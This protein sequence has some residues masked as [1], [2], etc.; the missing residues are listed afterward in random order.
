ME[1]YCEGMDKRNPALQLPE[2][3]DVFL[4]IKNGHLDNDLKLFNCYRGIPICHPAHISGIAITCRA[5]RFKAHINQLL[6]MEL[7]KKTVIQS[8]HFPCGLLAELT[9]IHRKELEV[10]LRGFVYT[11]V[12]INKRDNIRIELQPPLVTRLKYGNKDTVARIIDMCIPS[13]AA[14]LGNRDLLVE[15][16]DDIRLVMNLATQQ[17]ER[18]LEVP[19]DIFRITVDGENSRFIFNLQHNRRSEMLMS[20]FIF[21]KQIEIIRELKKKQESFRQ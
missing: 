2:V 9:H 14:L 19:A 13:V 10:T 12:I 20:E 5:V 17:G 21:H 3:L 6:V 18:V 16:P 8:S 7:Q 4:R 11:D 15:R 1:R